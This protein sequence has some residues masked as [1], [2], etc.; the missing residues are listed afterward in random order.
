VSILFFVKPRPVASACMPRRIRDVVPGHCRHLP[1]VSL[2]SISFERLF[3]GTDSLDLSGP[4][5]ES[6]ELVDSKRLIFR[7]CGIL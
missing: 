4:A 5:R 7:Y 6:K 3:F 2:Y 1:T